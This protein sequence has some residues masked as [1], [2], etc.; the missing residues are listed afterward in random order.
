VQTLAANLPT[1]KPRITL[2]TQTTSVRCISC[3]SSPSVFS[4]QKETRADFLSET[5]NVNCCFVG[6]RLGQRWASYS[7]SR[8]PRC[9]GYTRRHS[10]SRS[11][12]LL[13]PPSRRKNDEPIPSEPRRSVRESADVALQ[14]SEMEL[15]KLTIPIAASRCGI[16]RSFSHG[17]SF[18]IGGRANYESSKVATNWHNW[19]F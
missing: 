14:G 15:A 1:P 9:L 19:Q 6:F 8:S 12:R 13:S 4:L 5:C 10:D 18:L 11:R 2:P 3:A 17:F 16:F 7:P